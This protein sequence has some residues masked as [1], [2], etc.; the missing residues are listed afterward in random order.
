[1]AMTRRTFVRDRFVMDT[2]EELTPQDHL[3]RKLEDALDW[4]FIYPLVEN[5]YSKYGRPSI[6]PVILFKMVFINKIFGLNSMRR[7]CEEINVNVA[8]RWFLGLPFGEPI[9]NYSTWSQ[10]YIRRFGNSNVFDSIFNHIL[11]KIYDLK[12]LDLSVAYGDSTHRKA[13]ANKR[14]VTDKEVEIEA[15]AYDKELLDEI[16]EQRKLDGK[17]EFDS[18]TK[19]E[20]EFDEETGEEVEIKKT[21]HIKESKTDPESGAYHKGEH[22]KCF[23][24]SE[25]I[26]CDSKGYVLTVH[27]APGNVHDSTSFFDVYSKLNEIFPNQIT[28]ICL[29][30][31]YKTPAIVREILENNQ[32]PFLP[33][34][35]TGAKKSDFGKKHFEY[36]RDGDFYTCP[37]GNRLEY[38]NTNREGY[39]QYRSKKEECDEC[40]F[41]EQCR[42]KSKTKMIHRHIWEDNIDIAETI[43]KSNDWDLVYPTRKMS[44]ERV[45]GENKENGC[46][47]YTRV[48]GL[49]KNQHDTLMIFACHNLKKMAKHMKKD[50]KYVLQ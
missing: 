3:V 7:T 6:D 21:K 33:Y 22:E 37:C 24:Y 26:F 12:F 43:R 2:L 13:D 11:M 4:D 19:T 27:T 47:R 23:A 48:R 39:K 46:L 38:K 10:N 14:K 50:D 41:R 45:F 29:D 40:P 15:R 16:N 8:Y 32:I 34:T 17:K 1:M 49:K 18:I 25:S 35:R 30:A 28:G 9:P 42:K 36:D 20:Y 5:L 44:V 31:G